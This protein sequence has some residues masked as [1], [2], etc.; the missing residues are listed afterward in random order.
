M[1]DERRPVLGINRRNLDFVFDDPR[2]GRFRDLDDK[3][4]GKRR[5]EAAHVTVPRTLGVIEDAGDGNTLHEVLRDRH[6]LVVKPARGSGGRGILVLE[7]DGETWRTPG[8][9]RLSV[10]QVEEHVADVLSG[11]FSLDEAPDAVVLEERIRPHSFLRELYPDGLSDLRIVVED[12]EPIQAMLR[13][14]TD[15]SDGRANLH[16]G[17]L[18]LG[19]D[20]DTGRVHHA[21]QGRRP[22]E[23]HPDTGVALVGRGVPEWDRCLEVARA[24]ASAF[25]EIRYLG[26][27]I[28]LDA[29]RGPMVLE[30]NARPGLAIQVANREGQPVRRRVAPGRFERVTQI[31]AWLVLALL[32]VTPAVFGSWQDRSDT[33]V[34]TVRTE[35]ADAE[36]AESIV[37]SDGIE[38]SDE[39]VPI[40]SVDARFARARKAAAA[41]DTTT[42][43]ALYRE[44]ARDPSLAPFAMNNIALIH[45][46]NDD[47]PR[48]REVLESALVAHPDYARGSYNLGLILRDLGRT[49][50]AESS[51]RRATEL[52][53]GYARA[54][55]E[56][57]ELQM[58]GGDTLAARAS[59]EQAVRF[60]P[61]A[62]ADRWRL[63]RALLQSGQP[64]PAAER[65]REAVVLGGGDVATKDWVVARLVHT[66]RTGAE[67]S[68]ASLDSFSEAVESIATSADPL[69]S[70]TVLWGEL[71][72]LRG[73]L[74]AALRWFDGPTVE[75]HS[76]RAIAV[77]A[78]LDLETGRWESARRRLES[79]DAPV[80]D[81]LRGALRLAEAVDAGRG[82]ETM[83]FDRAPLL[84][85]ARR[86]VLERDAS[87]VLDTGPSVGDE[88]ERAWRR[89]GQVSD[90]SG[91]VM[92]LY[93]TDPRRRLP[94][95]ATLLSWWTS[96]AGGAEAGPDTLDRT[97]PLFV[98]R[99][100][101]RFEASAARGDFDTAH[102][103]GMRL[104]DLVSR[105]EPVILTLVDIELQRDEPAIARSLLESIPRNSRSRPDVQ[106]AEAR[107]LRAEGDDRAAREVLEDLVEADPLDAELRVELARVQGAT[108]RWRAATESWREATR[109]VPDR[110]DW[111]VGLAH[112]LMERRRYDDAVGVWN[113]ALALPLG[114]DTRRSAHFNRALALQREDQ[115]EPAVAGWDSVLTRRPDSRS[116][117][118][119]R[120]LALQRLDRRAAAIEAYRSVLAI[121]PDHEASRERLAAL[122]EETTP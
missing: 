98:P 106:R 89:T 119:N 87:L 31:T 30:M 13:V 32:L 66:A 103:S 45:R 33:E 112:S 73:D 63:G 21:V 61:D 39:G 56:L 114:P 105:P 2:P 55:S 88:V 81:R 97:S 75:L 43:L 18:G 47:L 64:G 107:V 8:G 4:R 1:S 120:A 22:V 49:D 116:A 12:G 7:R 110:G 11:S 57:G 78:L 95:P 122:L 51:F 101:E 28:V 58:D 34:R 42:A 19:I 72:W 108:E 68:S 37:E 59:L 24:A 16:G 104:I 5:L 26:V 70:A 80:L 71:L 69:S 83:H 102:A 15:A 48:A 27:D 20:L 93:G 76:V 90:R 10:E 86:R 46:A 25:G 52:R 82:T 91:T 85:L 121:D 117:R 3:L 77:A 99:L 62:I 109:L 44:A 6:E 115:L 74:E 111:Y 94:L 65:L 23:S 38:W 67:L 100:R 84:E 79:S 53:A 17:G 41:G 92:R 60:D 96:R 29:A 50:A 35:N 9:R 118:F 54:W 40:S 14:P 36:D 113:R